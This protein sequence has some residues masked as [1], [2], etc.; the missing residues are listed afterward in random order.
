MQFF[1]FLLP[2]SFTIPMISKRRNRKVKIHVL[3][4]QGESNLGISEILKLLNAINK[5]I[6]ILFKILCISNVVNKTCI[7]SR[8][9]KSHQV[10]L[11][12][13]FSFF[14]PQEYYIRDQKGSSSSYYRKKNEEKGNLQQ[15]K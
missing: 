1:F 10:A 3:V 4:N 8:S 7:S 5:D 2:F 14:L 12:P 11:P 15:L 6:K 9:F 13:L